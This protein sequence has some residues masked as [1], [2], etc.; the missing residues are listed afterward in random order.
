M[1]S[2]HK[3]LFH[4][5]NDIDNNILVYNALKSNIQKG[6]L[7]PPYIEITWIDKLNSIQKP[8][9]QHIQNSFLG[10]RI[11]QD[12]NTSRYKLHTQFLPTKIIT[13]HMKKSGSVIAKCILNNKECVLNYIKIHTTKILN[14]PTDMQKF[15]I[16]G[17]HT[18]T[19][20]EK[21]TISETH[22]ISVSIRKD[23]KS[24]FFSIGGFFS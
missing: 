14:V 9:P 24:N 13:I 17:T 20:H 15:T 23:L 3:Y 10:F 11:L 21:M 18:N 8:I 4:V 5:E 1:T 19:N 7:C 2:T 6:I 22:D 12:P 16:Y